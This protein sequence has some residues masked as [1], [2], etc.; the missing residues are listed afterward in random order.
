MIQAISKEDAEPKVRFWAFLRY[1]SDN[2]PQILSVEIEEAM[3]ERV[4]QTLKKVSLPPVNLE[5]SPQA[6]RHEQERA[7][8]MEVQ[9][10]PA[11]AARL[12]EAS[13]R[14][15]KILE[16]RIAS[17]EVEVLL[18]DGRVAKG[19]RLTAVKEE[20][21]ISREDRR[22]QFAAEDVKAVRRAFRWMWPFASRG[23]VEI[24]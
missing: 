7:R 4:E 2:H 8:G 12:Y 20:A 18:A 24:G 23:W 21:S 17:C 13:G 1:I 11:G 14:W 5:K 6:K 3:R 9:L 15:D 19:F 10:S 22:Y 16:L